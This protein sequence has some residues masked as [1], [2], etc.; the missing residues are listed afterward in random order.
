MKKIKCLFLICCLFIVPVHSQA[1][2][3]DAHLLKLDQIAGQAL[4]FTKAGRYEEAETQLKAVR[5]ELVSMELANS[6]L[7]VED[8]TVLTAVLNETLQVISSPEG[9]EKEV[10]NSVT[11]FRLAVD[12]AASRYQPLWIEM[13]QPVMASLQSLKNSSAAADSSRFHEALN[14]FLA[15]YYM[16][17]PSLK[18]DISEKSARLLDEQVRY[19]ALNSE[20]VFAEAAAE[21]KVNEL[22]KAVEMA[23][24]E[25]AKEDSVQPSLG[26]MISITGG[27]IIF[28][29][30]YVGWR[31]YKGQKEEERKKQNY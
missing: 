30:S 31:K 29:L 9:K 24:A 10:L 23:F 19:M 14:I 20:R 27:I 1:E 2:D 16:I 6:G 3:A 21:A 26:W 18:V 5:L 25:M 17:E 12:A 28:T 8:W 15:K 22:E 4:D 13:E 7:S 11:T